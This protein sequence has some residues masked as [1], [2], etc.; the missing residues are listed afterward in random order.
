[1]PQGNARFGPIVRGFSN[2]N[3][4]VITVDNTF[5]VSAAEAIHVGNIADD[6][7]ALSLNGDYTIASVTNTTITLNEDTSS[8]ST[9]ISGGFVT[10]TQLDEPIS[11][12]PPYNAYNNVPDYWNQA[13]Q[14]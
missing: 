6:Q 1:M 14:I 11:P 12:N 5:Q 13:N 8:R 9:Y 2:T 7:S 4:G 10:V 3:P